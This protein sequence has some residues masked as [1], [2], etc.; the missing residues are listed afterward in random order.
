MK[1]IAH[2][3]FDHGS[4]PKPA[5]RRLPT[6]AGEET[7]PRFSP[8][9]RELAFSGNYDGNIDIYVMPMGGGVPVRVTHHPMEDRVIGWYPDGKLLAYQ[10][11]S[12]EFRTW[13]RYRGGMTSEI[14]FFD[15]DKNTAARLPDGGGANNGMP[16]WHGSQLYFL[17]D[18]DACK[19]NNASGWC[20]PIKPGA[21]T[22]A[23]WPRARCRPSTRPSI[24]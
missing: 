17:S 14:W 2:Q 23:T 5:A 12:T 6:P 16:M 15:L 13:K 22:S 24:T 7:F 11:I 20:S 9:G 1:R 3:T 10:P 4:S 8:D 18:R 19:R 21:S